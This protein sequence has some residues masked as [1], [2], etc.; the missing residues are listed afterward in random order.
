M[1]NLM[2]RTNNGGR[3]NYD[4]IL[5]IATSHCAKPSERTVVA[6]LDTNNKANNKEI[7]FEG[8]KKE[9]TEWYKWFDSELRVPTDPKSGWVMK[10]PEKS[11]S[12]NGIR[13][14]FG[15]WNESTKKGEK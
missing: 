8:T 13:T 5:F 9:V 12:V 15:K 3:I 10:Y 7:L 6:I 1:P 2:I 11:R 4:K 14:V